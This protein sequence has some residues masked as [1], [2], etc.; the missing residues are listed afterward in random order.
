MAVGNFCSQRFRRKGSQHLLELGGTG[1]TQ[2][3]GNLLSRRDKELVRNCTWVG[4]GCRLNRR[5]ASWL[6]SWQG[7]QLGG[8][9][10]IGQ[11]NAV[12]G[13]ARLIGGQS[14]EF[15]GAAR[16][17][18]INSFGFSRL[19]LPDGEVTAVLRNVNSNVLDS[20]THLIIGC[21][22][23]DPVIRTACF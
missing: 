4:S 5:F 9:T 1:R 21:R 2:R 6:K 20:R 22:P 11:G 23:S 8:G 14:K 7:T 18:Q 3:L 10:V 17:T 12:G 13:V 16:L 19:P 15:L